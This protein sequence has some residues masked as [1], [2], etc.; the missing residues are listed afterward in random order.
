G[1]DPRR[2]IQGYTSKKKGQAFEAIIAAACRAY[3]VE[4]I[5]YID[6]TPEPMRVIGRGQKGQFMAIFE[7]KAQPDFKGKFWKIDRSFEP[8][9]SEE[10]REERCFNW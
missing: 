7:K 5:V 10:E 2:Q 9:I 6:K 8:A 3:R 1:K 4:R